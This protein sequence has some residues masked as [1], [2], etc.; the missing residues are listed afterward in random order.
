MFLMITVMDSCL[1]M[2]GF[3]DIESLDVLSWL[4]SLDIGDSGADLS[5]FLELFATMA[6][7]VLP[8]PHELTVLASINVTLLSGS[9]L[10]GLLLFDE[11]LVLGPAIVAGI[12]PVLSGW[13]TTRGTARA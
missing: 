3:A 2:T 4:K 6:L 12:V 10:A 13:L 1:R 7:G 8:G 11:P 5:Q 9:V